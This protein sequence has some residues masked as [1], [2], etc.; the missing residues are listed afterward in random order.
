MKILYLSSPSFADCDMPLIRALQKKGHDVTYLLLL[1]PHNLKYTIIDINANY[2]K[3]GVFHASVYSELNVFK[4]YLD[5]SKF[6]VANRTSN[7]SYSL[8]Y[9]RKTFAIWNFIR[10]NDFDIVHTTCLFGWRRLILYMTRKKFI[11]TI[12]DPFP[13]SGENKISSDYE[14]K[15]AVKYSSGIV[16]LNNKQKDAFCSYYKVK[17]DKICISSL[18]IYENIGLMASKTKVEKSRNILFFGRISPYKG[19]EY[20]CQAIEIVHKEMPDI[21]LTIAGSGKIYFDIKPY[22]DQGYIDFQNRFISLEEMVMM[23]QQCS[24]CVCPYTDATQSGVIMTSFALAKPVI[25]S[26]VGGLEEMIEDGKS[27]LL[28][29]PKNPQELANAIIHLL[30]N[31]QKLEQME[32]YIR[33]TYFSGKKSWLSIAETYISFYSTII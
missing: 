13:H 20:L 25:A 9:L 29:K 6:Y 19:I 32:D 15:L 17:Q 11:T 21:K 10:K 12:H 22:L 33:T 2:S 23:L 14:R 28:V 4:N 31:P 18:S 16:L 8:S 7:K 3:T 26:N 30:N 1:A 24:I 5:F 27:G